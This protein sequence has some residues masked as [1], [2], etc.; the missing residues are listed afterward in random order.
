LEFI[1]SSGDNV[2]C[3]TEGRKITCV[4]DDDLAVGQSMLVEVVTRVNAQPGTV[5]SNNAAVAGAGQ[6]AT[7]ANNVAGDS[8]MV[9]D[10]A[11]PTTAVSNPTGN[12]AAPQA[13]LGK[14]PVAFTGA[15]SKALTE[16]AGLLLLI[17][18]ALLIFRRRLFDRDPT[19]KRRG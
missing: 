19:R 1:S 13:P 18:A 11:P 12:P 10:G 16:V 4:R 15:S 2:E 6:E 14:S 17:G 5:V 9:G 8:L 3:R 7:M